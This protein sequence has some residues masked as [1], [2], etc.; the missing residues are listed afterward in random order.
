MVRLFEGRF[1]RLV[2]SELAPQDEVHAQADPVIVM[3]Q[4]AGEVLFLNPG[5]IHV[6]LDT[7]RV[8]ALH[9]GGEWL[10]ESFPAAFSVADP[11]PFP[12]R[13]EPVTL[14][15][16]RLAD[17]LVVEAM[18]DRF[19]SPERLNS[20]CRSSCSRSSTYMARKRASSP[21]WRG[22]R[23]EDSRIR[24]AIALRAR[25][26]KDLSIDELASQVGLSRSRFTICS[27]CAP[28]SRRAPT[29]TCCASSCNFSPVLRA[30]KMRRPAELGFSAQSNF[31]RFFLNQVGVPPPSTAAPLRA[32]AQTICRRTS[33]P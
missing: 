6:S 10:R 20:C 32:R 17:T 25:P 21:L 19:L 2:L 12:Q 22:S 7:S 11:H 1:G 3:Q 24:R 9:A 26:N 28:A 13:R 31:T 15:I 30:G 33:S 14:R 23:F 29:S 16:Q 18:N 4:G 5:E 27:S 8:L